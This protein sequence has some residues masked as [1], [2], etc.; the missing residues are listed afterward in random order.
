MNEL[1][2]SARWYA[3]ITASQ[4]MVLAIA[5]A[6]WIFDVYEGQLFTIYKTPMLRELVGEHSASVSRHGDVAFA[7]FLVGG[8]VGGLGFAMLGDRIGRVRVMSLTILVYSLFSALTFFARSVWEVDALRFLVALGT[9]GEWAV[10]AALVAET[11]PPRARAFASGIFHASSVLGAA[12]ASLTGWLV[13]GPGAWRWGF[14]VGL[15][16]ALLIVWIRASLKEPER[17]EKV[18]QAADKSP[19]PGGDDALAGE[20]HE[21]AQALGS[22][23]ELLGDRRWRSRALLGLG[24]AAVGLATYWGIYAWAPELVADVLGPEVSAEDRQKSASLAYLLMNFTGG[25]LGLLC[26]APVA[27]WRGRRFAFVAYHLGALVLVPLTFLGARTYAQTLMLLPTMAFFVVGMHAGYAI[28]FPELFPTRLRATGSSFCFNLGRL[29]AAVFLIAR[30]VLGSRFDF[31]YGVVA[32]AS[33]FLV[34]LV[35]LVFAPETRGADLP[36]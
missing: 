7:L 16:P 14:L 28:Y 27:N 26:F 3:G 6:G 5:S 22:L 13:V 21:P 15:A 35:L 4:W 17:W 11:F 8:A 18:K 2:H 34:G 24:L 32:M 20:S 29:V 25:L 36:E 19:A 10:A 12:L 30:G 31:R 9:G 33:L 23:R 1:N